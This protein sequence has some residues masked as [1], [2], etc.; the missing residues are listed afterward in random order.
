MQRSLTTR[1]VGVRVLLVTALVTAG[2]FSG[3][4]L[5]QEASAEVASAID[6]AP[7]VVEVNTPP[8]TP[9]RPTISADR[10]WETIEADLSCSPW[11]R[12]ADEFAVW[13]DTTGNA[14][15]TYTTSV[16]EKLRELDYL[17]NEHWIGRRATKLL[18]T[19]AGTVAAIV[20]EPGVVAG[21][22]TLMLVIKTSPDWTEALAVR[23]ESLGEW[24]EETTE[25]WEDYAE[26]Y[27]LASES[28]SAA[29]IEAWMDASQTLLPYL[30][31]GQVL[32]T[33]LNEHLATIDGHLSDLDE[34]LDGMDHWT[35]RW[36]ADE[37]N[38]HV[39]APTL[40]TVRD[41]RPKLQM[42]QGRLMI[43]RALI[44]TMPLRF[45]HIEIV[46]AETG[47]E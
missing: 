46:D 11:L 8:V 40:E 29:H 38:T 25:V 10:A 35:V 30:E 39:V 1:R 13:I 3:R 36:L 28:P 5:T 15:Q 6:A 22:G 2:V 14:C 20:P 42:T 27:K 4:A 33:T 26:A 9:P 21:A 31:R 19:G 23:V 44:R 32:V 17:L 47:V 16:A 12:N 7:A 41:L 43:D 45:T 37:T 34:Y 24:I 18:L